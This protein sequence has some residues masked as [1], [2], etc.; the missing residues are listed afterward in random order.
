M[1]LLFRSLG[2]I[3][4]VGILAY[5]GLVIFAYFR[6][7]QMIFPCPPP[8]YESVCGNFSIPLQKGA[9]TNACFWEADNNQDAYT[10]I[11]SPGNR[12]DLGRIEE[13]AQQFTKLGFNVLGYEYPG[14]GR[15]LGFP[16]EESVYQTA[17]AV[18]HYALNELKIKPSKIILYGISLGSGPSVELA[19]HYPIAGLILE[20]AFASTFRVLTRWK[21]LTWDCFDN[22]KKMNEITCP[23]LI[24]HG[25]N[26][27]IV[28]AYHSRWLLE[29]STQAPKISL[30]VENAQHTNASYVDPENYNKALVAFMN[31][32]HN[33]D[34]LMSLH[35]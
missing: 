15:T 20:G 29:A 34:L 32:I 8:S 26:D 16:T 35:P 30:F 24:I 27:D 17:D 7:H 14:C 23:L 5:V 1:H 21:L 6:A 4:L 19:T 31:L 10:L 13:Y 3:I 25:Q 18:Y 33:K 2:L 22:L 28:P 12:Q 9:Y 11:Y